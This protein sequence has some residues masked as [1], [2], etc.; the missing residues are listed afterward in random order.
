[1]KLI[2]KT[3]LITG[4]SRGFG[5][6]VAR[7]F[8]KEGARVILCGRD[9]PALQEAAK[10]LSSSLVF[11]CDIANPLD[12]Q[13]LRDFVFKEA[14]TLD[15]LV[16]N[17]GVYGP[18]GPIE[19]IDSQEWMRAFEINLFGLFHCCQAFIP[20]FKK[21][22]Y[23]KIINLSGGGAT[24]PLPRFSSYAASKAAVVRLTETMAMEL[25]EFGIDVN[26][27]APGSLNTRLLDQVLEAGP[28]QTGSVFYEKMLL[29]KEEGGA[30]LHRGAEL[31]VYL[32]SDESNGI[33]G[34]LLAA[35]WDPWETLHT[36]R[37][38]LQKTDIYNL[39]RII[40]LDRGEKWGDRE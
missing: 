21:Q 34:K 22:K 17:A 35:L 11:Q 23:G 4:G 40:P 32:A 20:H 2:D 7:H 31:C 3:A 37:E 13:A 9:L 19:N 6:E 18:I 33:T 26:A 36:R 38:L 39:R 16:N 28:E 27:I 10:S 29:Q 1:M 25:L 5:L 15:I 14:G 12:V 30:P 8:E 24:A